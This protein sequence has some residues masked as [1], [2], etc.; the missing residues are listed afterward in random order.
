MEIPSES[1]FVSAIRSFCRVFFGI[2]ALALAV[3]VLAIAYS[4]F[5]SP[6]TPEVN[7]TVKLLPDL[8]QEVV[9]RSLSSPVVLQINFDS[10]IGEPKLLDSQSIENILIDSRQDFLAKDRVKAILLRMNTPGGTVTDAD[11]VYRMLKRYKEKHHVPVFAYVDGLCASGGMYIT[12]AA[13]KIYASPPSLV[14]SV[15]VII[16]PFFNVI[17]GLNRIGIQAK[18]LT[19]GLDKDAMNPFRTWKPNE[20]ANYQAMT[21]YFYQRFVDIV[22]SARPGL[23]RDKLVKEYGANVFVGPEALARGYIDVANAEYEQAL[24]DLMSAAGIDPTKEY[25]VVALK[26]TLNF[27]G[28]PVST[29]LG[30]IEHSVKLDDKQW[31]R[32][33]CSYLYE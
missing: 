4:C 9:L 33:K 12:A 1:I 5:Y 28:L 2:I 22:T 25:Q 29:K 19:E 10:I 24:F 6:Y 15:G 11:N 21:A 8:N 3:L 14:G 32:D 30:N 23:D 26:P 20:D 7:T 13:D 16:G 27:L 31:L 18:T 17:D